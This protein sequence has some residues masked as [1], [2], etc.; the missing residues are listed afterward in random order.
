MKKIFTLVLLVLFACSSVGYAQK[1]NL[2]KGAKKNAKEYRVYDDAKYAF[3]LNGTTLLGLVNPAMEFKV[4]KNLT[5][6]LDLFWSLYDK[7]FWTKKHYPLMMG[8]GW[9]EFRYYPVEALHGFYIGAHLGGSYYKLNYNVIPL[10]KKHNYIKD[11]AYQVGGNVML[12]YAIGYAFTFKSNPHWGFEISL[13]G[14][15]HFDKYY[16]VNNPDKVPAKNERV[17]M[18]YKG[19]VP[20]YK[21]GILVTYRW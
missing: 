17:W 12:G 4:H 13:G 19:F 18:K 1:H 14:G 8:A 21:G 9:L 10:I 15:G 20:I 6:Q 7:T 11:E 2:D 5:L 16:H 3:K